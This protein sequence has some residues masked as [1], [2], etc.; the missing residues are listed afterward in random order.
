MIEA[1]AGLIFTFGLLYVLNTYILFPKDR[2]MRNKG[3]RERHTGFGEPTWYEPD[4]TKRGVIPD[5]DW[6]A[7]GYLWSEKYHR[8]YLPK[9]RS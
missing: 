6:K 9:K 4:P 1:L 7:R 2:E 5:E 8:W 3:Y